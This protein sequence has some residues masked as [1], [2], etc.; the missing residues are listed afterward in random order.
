MKI[1][2]RSAPLDMRLTHA[3]RRVAPL[4]RPLS[5]RACARR[6]AW[7]ASRAS[8]RPVGEAYAMHGRILVLLVLA[9][10]VRPAMADDAGTVEHPLGASKIILSDGAKPAERR[11]VF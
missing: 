9:L 10:A 8:K 2:C 1:R 11:I 4:P 5:P 7:H 3:F 6:C